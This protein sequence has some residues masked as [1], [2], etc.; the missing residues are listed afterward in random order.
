[1]FL[2]PVP[3]GQD[4][5]VYYMKNLPRETAPGTKWVYKTG[6]TNLIGVLVMRATHEPLATYLSEK[7]WKPYGMERDAFWM[8]DPAAHEGERLLPFGQ[9][10][11]LCADGA[12]RARGGPW[13][14]SRQL[15]RRIDAAARRD[16]RAGAMA[17]GING[18][19]IPRAGSAP[20]AS[21]ARRSA[22]IPGRAP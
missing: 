9:P 15:V 11:R 3:A 13:R 10:A 12:V 4:P 22:S 7:V 17:T 16:R 18:G 5:T 19:P 8:I 2:E 20:R 1:M 21:S 14:S 6:E